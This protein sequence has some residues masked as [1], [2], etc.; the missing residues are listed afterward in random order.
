MKKRNKENHYFYKQRWV[1]VMKNK[2][3][4]E[5]NIE[6]PFLETW[7]LVDGSMAKALNLLWTLYDELKHFKCKS[8]N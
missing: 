5:N 1:K 4:Y 3:N 2:S 6:L 8:L 7:N